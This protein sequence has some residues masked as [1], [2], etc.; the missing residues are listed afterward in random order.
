MCTVACAIILLAVTSLYRESKNTFSSI[1]TTNNQARYRPYTVTIPGWV[2]GSYDRRKRFL[3]F[4]G[5]LL[6]STVTSLPNNIKP[7]DGLGCSFPAYSTLLVMLQGLPGV[8]V[9]DQELESV[10]II[11]NIIK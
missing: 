5:C 2:V 4:L 10:V 8:Y 9:A 7:Q 1:I 3:A 6:P 11:I